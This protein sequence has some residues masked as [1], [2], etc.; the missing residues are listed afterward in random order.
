VVYRCKGYLRPDLVI[1]ILRHGTIEILGIVDSDLL[2][3]SVATDDVLPE[4]FLDGG[5]GY[6][7]YRLRFNPFGEVLRCD[8]GEGVISLHFC[9]FVHDIDAPPP[10]GPAWS[11]Q[12]RRLR[13]S[14]T[15]MRKFLI[16]FAGCY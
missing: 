13:E 2:R 7:R 4:K 9:K 11:Y 14:P 3:D 8:N 15:M 12:Q 1:E 5:G 10:Q 6:I 16:G